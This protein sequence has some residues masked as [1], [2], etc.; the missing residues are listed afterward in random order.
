LYRSPTE[1]RKR[2]E[3]KQAKAQEQREKLM[4]EKAERLKE[5]SKKVTFSV[6]LGC[7]M[8]R[9]CKIL[10]VFFYILVAFEKDF[11]MITWKLVCYSAI[12]K[13]TDIL[14]NV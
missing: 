4:Q 5:L 8:I 14:R 6:F 2:H 9:Y 11:Q 13:V 7:Y 10:I 3:E 1:S 12:S